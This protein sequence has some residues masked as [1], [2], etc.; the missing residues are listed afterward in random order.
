MDEGCYTGLGPVHQTQCRFADHPEGALASDEELRKI[1]Y[2]LVQSVHQTE[3]I[4]PA[5]VFAD[6]WSF[7]ADQVSLLANQL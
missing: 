1:E 5:T 7:G 3:Q 2:R 4:V 6:G